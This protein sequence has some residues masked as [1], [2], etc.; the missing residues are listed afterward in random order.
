MYVLPLG[1]VFVRH[2]RIKHSRRH[3]LLNLR[4]ELPNLLLI[5]LVVVVGALLRKLRNAWTYELW[6]MVY[7]LLL[8]L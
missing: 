8:C 5:L 7:F 2:C 4:V 1:L 3:L 6:A